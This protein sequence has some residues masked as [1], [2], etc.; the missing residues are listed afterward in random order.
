ML[1]ASSATVGNKVTAV[2][3][4][5]ASRGAGLRSYR[6]DQPCL[7]WG[8]MERKLHRNP[9]RISRGSSSIFGKSG[10]HCSCLRSCDLHCPGSNFFAGHANESQPHCNRSSRSQSSRGT[11]L[12]PS[13]QGLESGLE[14]GRLSYA[15]WAICSK[16]V[17]CLVLVCPT[18]SHGVGSPISAIC[19]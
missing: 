10:T 5:L 12:D 14:S 15:I 13:F 8:D 17:H 16:Q 9:A 19:G 6:E 1:F 2:L 11:T 18:R 7:F 3:V 4:P